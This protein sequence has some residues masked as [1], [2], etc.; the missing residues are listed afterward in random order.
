MNHSLKIS[1]F[2]GAKAEENSVRLNC[3]RFI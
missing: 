3:Y 2:A 1:E